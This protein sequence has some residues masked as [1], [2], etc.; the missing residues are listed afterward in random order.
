MS[1]ELRNVNYTYMKKTPYERQALKNLSLK[2]AKGEFVAIIG[3]TGSG[4]STL[5]QHLNG[6]LKP[7]SG[8]ASVDGLMF[9]GG[10]DEARK[11]RGKVGMVFQYPEHQLFAETIFEDVAFGPRNLGMQEAQVEGAVRDA[12]AFVDLDYG[13]FKARSPF[14][15]SGGQ[16]RRVAIAGVVAMQ[17]D[18]L[19]LDEPSAGLDPGTRDRIFSRIMEL[20]SKRHPAIILVTHNMD[21]AVRYANRLLVMN[22]GRL[23]L[24]GNPAEIFGKHKAELLKASLD[25]PALFKLMARFKEKGIALPEGITTKKDL[26]VELKRRIAGR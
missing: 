18:Y 11:A 26:L 17:P 3:H 19:I 24:D 7:D 12:L 2:I 13:E 15:L 4:K 8:S 23:L 9:S 16:M 14:E 21:E 6:L 10:K 20:Y 5:V 1:L 25:E 22:D